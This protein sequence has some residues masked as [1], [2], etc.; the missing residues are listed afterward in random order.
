MSE[1]VFIVEFASMMK[2]KGLVI[3][4]FTADQYGLIKP[5]DRLLLKRPDGSF[6]SAKTVGVDYPPSIKWAGERPEIPRY[7][8]VIDR[9]DVPVGTEVFLDRPAT[10]EDSTGEAV[11]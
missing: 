6:I 3:E 8:I 1:P 11:Q 7:G 10:S 9:Y 5:G 2:G 4:G